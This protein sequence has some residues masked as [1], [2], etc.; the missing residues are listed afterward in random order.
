MSNDYLDA[1]FDFDFDSEKYY[2]QGWKAWSP[3]PGNCKPCPYPMTSSRYN[4][5]NRGYLDA[6]WDYEQCLDS[7][8]ED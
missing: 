6:A 4:E 7:V 2:D 8:W 5:W 1:D 3:F